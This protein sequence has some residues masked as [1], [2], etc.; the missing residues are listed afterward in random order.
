MSSIAVIAHSGKSIEGGLPELRR[1]LA[2]HGVSDPL[3]VEVPKSKKAPKQ[4]RRL[5]RSGADHFFV[6]GGDGMAQRCIDA[7]AGT[8]A[9]IALVPAGTANL[10]ATNLGIPK[11]IA[12]AVA[13]GLDGN[14]RKIDVVT[15][16]GERFAVMAGTGFDADMIAG[17][18]GGLKD[19]LGRAAYLW[20]GTKSIRA[21]PF[22]AR[23][24][25]DGAPWYRGRA[26][27]IL[28]GN[29]GSLFGGV[30]VFPDAEPDDGLVDLAVITADGVAQW[31]E[32][33]G[34]TIAGRSQRSAHVRTT[35]AH[36]VK[37][38]LD[39]KVLYE[40]DGGARTK[41][42]AYRLE[43]EPRAI[44]VRVP[45]ETRNGDERS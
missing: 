22:E 35:K 34:R 7:L 36:A 29:V 43:V 44:A 11:D 19:R 30:R 37:V 33:V 40:L 12:G 16:N 26:S 31:A 41:V 5:L 17:A 23:I 6:W 9:T 14:V 1:A 8:G 39:R 2:R 21:E 3:W 38:R 20:T 4:V 10:L 15:M 28:A 42:K 13:T 45:H 32:T 18:D 24:R 27:C 25:V